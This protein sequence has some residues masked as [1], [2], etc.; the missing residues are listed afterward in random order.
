MRPADDQGRIRCEIDVDFADSVS[1]TIST[2][3]LVNFPRPRFA[4]LPVQIGVELV[5]VGGTLSVQIH[6]PK[7]DRQHLHV[8][9][10]PDFHLNLKTTSLLGSRAKLQGELTSTF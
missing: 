4:V 2:A 9:L 1:L 5:S 10:L 3:V 7:D 8:C 6:H